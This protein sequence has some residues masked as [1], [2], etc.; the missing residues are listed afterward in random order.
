[1]GMHITC[2][3][4][5][6]LSSYRTISLSHV[7]SQPRGMSGAWKLRCI[8]SLTVF[9]F[10]LHLQVCITPCIIIDMAASLAMND[11]EI[12]RLYLHNQCTETTGSRDP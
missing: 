6:D 12:L 11:P 7:Q 2:F 10:L 9:L 3:G 4:F 5:G 8:L 1:M